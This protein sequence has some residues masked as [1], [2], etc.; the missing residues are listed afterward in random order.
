MVEYRLDNGQ[1]DLYPRAW[2]YPTD[3]VERALQYFREHSA[4]PPFISW[5]NDSGDG[6]NIGDRGTIR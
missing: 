5:H 3:V 4:P 6:K 1:H 2:A